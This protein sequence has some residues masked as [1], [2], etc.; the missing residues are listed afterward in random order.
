MRKGSRDPQTR[1]R[2]AV[3]VG[4][5]GCAVAACASFGTAPDTG[6][7][8]AGANAVTDGKAVAVLAP[9]DGGR[10]GASDM[11]CDLQ[12]ANDPSVS[13][14]A[15]FHE[16]ASQAFPFGF[17]PRTLEATEIVNVVA[18]PFGGRDSKALDVVLLSGTGSREARLSA[19]VIR[20]GNSIFDKQITLDVDVMVHDR[21]IVYAVLANISVEGSGCMVRPGIALMGDGLHP[22]EGSRARAIAVALN[23]PFH[24]RID[25]TVKGNAAPSPQVITID[26]VTLPAEV[27]RYPAGCQVVKASIGAFYTS[28]E[29]GHVGVTYGQLVV[30]VH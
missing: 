18:S 30:R 21:E 24:V 12:R 20:A 9:A 16:Q 17:E 6:A 1:W 28:T 15:D 8:D 22:T 14:C 5:A 27:V 23:K 2:F 11:R 26:G 4:A 19:P 29:T 3:A 13:V 7:P 10:D 25:T